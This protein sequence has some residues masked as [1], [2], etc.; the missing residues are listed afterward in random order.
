[1]EPLQNYERISPR[2]KRKLEYLAVYGRALAPV[3][4]CQSVSC[5]Q[6]CRPRRTMHGLYKSYTGLEA[7]VESR[8]ANHR[9]SIE[10]LKIARCHRFDC[11]WTAIGPA[12]I[13]FVG[14]KRDYLSLASQ[15]ARGATKNVAKYLY[16]VS[17]RLKL[18]V[19]I[20]SSLIFGAKPN[21][22][23]VTIVCCCSSDFVRCKTSTLVQA[24]MSERKN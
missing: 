23:D 11:D 16:K 20:F 15:R 13:I 24:L 17:M 21:T 18:R 19:S 4:V 2:K 12:T 5:N 14:Q 9:P 7:R 6:Q 3:W 10:L 8:S 1:V 22:V